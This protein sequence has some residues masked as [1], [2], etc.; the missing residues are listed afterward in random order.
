MA[1]EGDSGEKSED[2][3]GRRITHARSEG[4][5]ARS[6]DLSQAL[7]MTAGFIALHY[8][9][10]GIWQKLIMITEGSLTSEIARQDIE[11]GA[12]QVHLARLIAALAPEILPIMLIAAFF[13]AGSTLLQ[14]N[15]LWS[16]K[17]F[18]PRFNLL[19]PLAGIKRIFSVQNYVQLLKA[20]AKL[21]IIGPV[22][23]LAF[24]DFLPLLVQMIDIP[25]SQHF[26]LLGEM[27][28][29]VF[30][31][32]MKFIFIIAILDYLWQRYSTKKRLK[33]SKQEVKEERKAMEGDERTKMLIRSKAMSRLR[34]K[35]MQAVKT[36]DVVV[37][38]PTQIAVAL[39]YTMVR[40]TAP[41]VVAKGR[42]VVAQRIRELAAEHGIPI[43]ERK[44]LA[45]ALYASV[46]VGKQ[47][48][49][50]LF[51]AVAELLAYVYRLKGKNH[52]GK[53]ESAAT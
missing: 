3:T 29:T 22:A 39:R 17:L 52:F 53:K 11:A 50:E 25:L 43:V 45:R 12:L 47:I 44:P 46:E 18:R 9:G 24:I 36:A 26:T 37:T 5:V 20:L 38:N 14:T 4:M 34:Q 42:G 8:Y 49:Y 27:M 51:T 33:M 23:Y 32:I 48:P 13:G 10:P 31:D 15:F 21:A 30:Y 41:E 35:M 28:N 7:S 40:G 6:V 1:E 16:S 2:P 19:S